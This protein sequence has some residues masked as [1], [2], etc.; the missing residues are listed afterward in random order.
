MKRETFFLNAF[1]P[2][3]RRESSSPATDR[4]R[5][6]KEAVSGKF[7]HT[8]FTVGTKRL[9]PFI[10]GQSTMEGT[11]ELSP[12]FA[13]NPAHQ[14]PMVI[15][16]NLGTLSQLYPNKLAV[17]LIPGSFFREHKALND[18]ASS[19][20]RTAR[21]LDFTLALRAL[22]QSSK[23]VYHKGEYYPMNGVELGS[24][25]KGDIQYFISGNLYEE[26]KDFSD[27]WF[28][29]SLRPLSDIKT[30]PPRSGF[31][32]G[33]CARKTTEEARKAVAEIFPEDEFG[34][35]MHEMSMGNDLTPWNRFLKDYS[36]RNPDDYEFYL[37]PLESFLSPAPFIVGSYQE[38]A[39]VL[40]KYE[41][42]GAGF[43]ILDYHETDFEHVSEVI[44]CFRKT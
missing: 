22:V 3:D 32:A 4:E 13:V 31:L 36:A 25:V 19:T 1:P 38:V 28:V 37:K 33:I 29:R 16:K 35:R 40:K 34:K 15:A 23:P 27:T 18:E 8:L 7:E 11:P 26:L 30:L 41:A 20:E 21:L 43:F 5:I 24:P 39:S 9:D 17:N 14:H 6:R 10:L 2:R 42:L 44:S 12:L